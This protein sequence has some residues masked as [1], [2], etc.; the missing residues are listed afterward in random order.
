MPIH[1]LRC[2]TC[3]HIQRDVLLSVKAD[4]LEIECTACHRRG[5]KKMPCRVHAKLVEGCGG[6]Y[7]P[8]KEDEG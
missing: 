2:V 4:P 1:D 6:F 8:S 7:K 3:G 5:V